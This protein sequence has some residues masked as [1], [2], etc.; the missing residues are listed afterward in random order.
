M[1]HLLKRKPVKIVTAILIIIIPFQAFSQSKSIKKVSQ[2]W[3]Q[4]YAT[5]KLAKRWTWSADAGYRY[6]QLFSNP[7]QYLVRAALAYQLGNKIKIGAGFAHLGF[8]NSKKISKLEYRPYEEFS[9][10]EKL[11][12]NL[13]IHQRFRIEERYF[14]NIVDGH[15]EPGTLFNFRFRYQF[16]M[17]FKILKLSTTK[18]D[19]TLL[20]NLGD[21]IFI[22]AGKE[23][24]YN[25]FDQNR[26]LIGPVISLNKNLNIGII[27]NRQFAATNLSGN[28]I[29]TDA[30]W[31][32]IKQHFDIR[33]RKD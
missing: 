17:N 11:N 8:Y 16:M 20:L 1:H 6:N 24:V 3:I 18:P 27:Y 25:T 12:N 9:M 22:N 5:G 32:T 2:Q 33:N 7:S 28:Y 4:Y 21:E 26:F 29:Q 14:R 23:I 31:L 15:V 19:R 10:V 30:F 13:D